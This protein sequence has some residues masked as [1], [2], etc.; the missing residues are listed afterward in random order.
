VVRAS[1]NLATL[2]AKTR[3]AAMFGSWQTTFTTFP[4]LRDE[5]SRNCQEERLLGVS[6]TGIMDHPVLN[7]VNDK[8]KK[9][10]ADLRGVAI[11]ETEKWSKVLGIN[12]S[13]A[14][15]TVKPSG[16]V[17]QLVDSASGIHTRY[18]SQYIR[19][20]RISVADPLFAMLRDQGVPWNPEVGQDPSTAST[21]V[22]DFPIAAPRGAKTRHDFTALQQ[23]DHWRMV[24]EFWCEHQP[25]VTVYVE[26]RE[27]P[28]VAAWVYD[29]F[30]DVCGLS[31]LPK[32]NHVYRLAPYEEITKE[33]FDQLDARFPVIDWSKLTEYENDDNTEGS[34]A[35]A[36]IGDRCEV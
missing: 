26:D 3:L 18:A 5:W 16:T 4:G 27:W 17:S 25:S 11:N 2:R 13:A 10:L 21:A 8:A 19:R 34:Q 15:T 35:L 28:A 29:N 7:N 24:K 9:W 6:L 22:L 31:F 36:C 14:I 33:Q 20:Y 30:D 12:M 23:L 1:D 32:Q